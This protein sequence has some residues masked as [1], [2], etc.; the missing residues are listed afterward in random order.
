M[1]TGIYMF[2]NPP[3]VYVFYNYWWGMQ[4]GIFVVLKTVLFVLSVF[5][6][7]VFLLKGQGKDGQGKRERITRWTN[8][9]K[10]MTQNMTQ[11]RA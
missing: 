8:S 6:A 2:Y 3:P 11:A 10:L 1:Q 4:K 9:Q 7:K 5:G